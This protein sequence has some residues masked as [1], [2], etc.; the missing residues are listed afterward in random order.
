[1]GV[2][3]HPSVIYIMI[4]CLYDPSVLMQTSFVI[5]MPV[6]N[7]NFDRLRKQHSRLSFYTLQLGHIVGGNVSFLLGGL[8]ACKPPVPLCVIE[9]LQVLPLAEA[10]ILICS[11]VVIIESD[12]YFWRACRSFRV[13][14]GRQGTEAVDGAVEALVVGCP[15]CSPTWV[16]VLRA[17]QGLWWNLEHRI[18]TVSDAFFW[19]LKGLLMK[20][21]PVCTR[22][23][24]LLF[25]FFFTFF[26]YPFT[27]SSQNVY[28]RRTWH[29]SDLFIMTLL[30][31]P[32]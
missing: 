26:F 27:C 11:G 23:S 20:L 31:V 8:G 28:Q 15:S 32:W 17:S 6:I 12:E 2:D 14:E 22:Y 16:I 25:S 3:M 1:M 30:E 9:D 13:R 10:Q 4:T 21:L 24:N 5:F 7:E 18:G 29:V 19:L